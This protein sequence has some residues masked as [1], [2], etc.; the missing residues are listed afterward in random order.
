MQRMDSHLA[1]Y[2][3]ASCSVWTRVL[4]WTESL[5]V[6]YG[7]ASC[8]VWTRLLFCVYLLLALEVGQV[9]ARSVL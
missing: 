9:R 1:A 4:L 3:L 7:L 6:L 8:S 2:G 5:L